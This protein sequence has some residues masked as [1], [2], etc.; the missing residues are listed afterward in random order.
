MEWNSE[1]PE[2]RASSCLPPA[3]DLPHWTACACQARLQE[4]LPDQVPRG[5]KAITSAG[6]AAGTRLRRRMQPCVPAR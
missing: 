2:P 1:T 3:L 6:A 4:R 5:G